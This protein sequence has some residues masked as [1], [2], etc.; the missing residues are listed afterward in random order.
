MECVFASRSTGTRIQRLPAGAIEYSYPRRCR[1]FTLLKRLPYITYGIDPR[2]MAHFHGS[3]G[4]S[5]PCCFVERWK[6]YCLNV[7]YRMNQQSVVLIHDLNSYQLNALLIYRTKSCLY[8]S[9]P[10]SGYHRH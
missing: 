10:Y 5:P 4:V 9:T 2:L 7:S 1:F 3:I 6:I 8:F